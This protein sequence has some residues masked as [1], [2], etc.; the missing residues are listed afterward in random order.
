MTPPPVPSDPFAALRFVNFRRLL[1]S[2]AGASFAGQTFTVVIGY[3][4]YQLTGS[5][6]A[7]GLLGL[8]TAVPTLSLALLGG[9]Y[10]D[11]RDRRRILLITRALLVLSGLAFALLSSWGGAA[12]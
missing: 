6:L 12:A 8:A 4:V 11:H 10:A 1:T 9:H 3:Q 5:A 7:L 2:S